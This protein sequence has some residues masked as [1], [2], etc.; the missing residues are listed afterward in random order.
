MFRTAALPHKFVW[1]D[2]QMVVAPGWRKDIHHMHLMQQLGITSMPENLAAGTY[3]EDDFTGQPYLQHEWPSTGV[4]PSDEELAEGVRQ[5]LQEKQSKVG[6]NYC[7]FGDG[8]RAMNW[9]WWGKSNLGLCDKHYLEL[10]SGQ[11]SPETEQGL[12]QWG[13]PAVNPGHP[14][15][16]AR[17]PW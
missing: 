6:E 17:K 14:G 5:Q 10:Q 12:A 1:A 13:L 11:V 2:G 4:V 16:V 3:S 15:R 8:Q 9:M 7:V